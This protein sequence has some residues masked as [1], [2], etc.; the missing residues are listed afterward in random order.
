MKEEFEDYSQEDIPS[1][2]QDKPI[3]QQWF[4][5]L[6]QKD[7]F[8]KPKYERLSH[9]MLGRCTIPHSNAECERLFSQVRKNKTDFQG[10]ISNTMLSALLINKSH[11]SSS[12][13]YNQKFTADFLQKAKAA[14]KEEV[15]PQ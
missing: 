6:L 14:T 7:V 11:T 2:F 9:F 1:D 4:Q 3:D 15:K 10:S 12:T 5:L 8:G 13:C